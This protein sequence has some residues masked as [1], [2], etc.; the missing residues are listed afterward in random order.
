MVLAP[1]LS[2]HAISVSARRWRP[3]LAP[4]AE[5]TRRLTGPGLADK[6]HPMPL[7]ALRGGLHHAAGR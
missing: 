5:P 3:C 4:G 1:G 6:I 7:A 2:E